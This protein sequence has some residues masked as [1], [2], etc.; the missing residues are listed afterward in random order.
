MVNSIL[1]LSFFCCTCR[2]LPVRNIGV[3][4][5]DPSTHSIFFSSFLFLLLIR[6]SQ[7][8][9]GKK[10]QLISSKMMFYCMRFNSHCSRL[11][12]KY[13]IFLC[14]QRRTRFFVA[15]RFLQSSFFVYITCIV[16]EYSQFSCHN[17]FYSSSYVILRLKRI[18]TTP[19]KAK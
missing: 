10:C 2:F 12:N 5:D 14:I 1:L 4:K 8:C 16:V 19:F 13:S 18:E 11:T 3:T 9:E 17:N 15:Y 7:G 6:F